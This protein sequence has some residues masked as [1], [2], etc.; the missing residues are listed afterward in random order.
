[1]EERIQ[2]TIAENGLLL[3]LGNSRTIVYKGEPKDISE[4]LTTIS[5]HLGGY[6]SGEFQRE[7]IK[8]GTA[9]DEYYQDNEGV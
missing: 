5:K 2:I 4:M 9:I 1:M 6:F 7:R 3:D 8:I